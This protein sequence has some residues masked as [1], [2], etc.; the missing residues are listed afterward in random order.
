MN[1]FPKDLILM[2]RTQQLRV[3]LVGCGQI[4]DAHLQQ[5]KLLPQ[6]E[7][8]GVCD[9]E[10]LLAR[11][12]AERFNVP[13][14]F[15]SVSEM[16][17]KA[18]PDVVH[19]TTPVQAHANLATELL[20]AG[21]H[22]YVEKPFTLNATDARRVLDVAQANQ[23]LVCLGH[24]QLFDPIWLDCRRIVDS[25]AIGE[26]QHVDSVLCYPIDGPFGATVVRDPS[27]WV[28]RLPGGLFHNTMSHPLYRITEFLDDPC[29]ALWAEWFCKL[30]SVPFPTELRVQLRGKRTTGS[31]L[32]M[33]TTKPLHRLTRV[34]GTKGSFE[35][36]LNSQ[37]IRMDRATK[38]PGAL[39]RLEAPLQQCKEVVS[40]LARNF[41]RFGRG[42]FNYFAGMRELFRRFYDSILDGA[43]PPIP[44]AE[45]IR[46][47]EIMDRIFENCR[48]QEVRQELDIE[49]E[50]RTEH[51]TLRL[52]E[53][54]SELLNSADDATETL[55][56]IPQLSQRR[57][58]RDM[59]VPAAAR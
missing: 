12:A 5:I 46:V 50:V 53:R 13:G 42:E 18:K 45:V 57:S 52:L 27:H 4:A 40:N 43:A 51:D 29:P 2:A 33:S 6:A 7:L 58:A 32:F 59:S 39:A 10:P 49:R 47:T 31:L 38:L 22:V 35:V 17:D 9:L 34:Y 25:G 55:S 48:A 14:Q 19:I 1:T 26:V 15:S 20:A 41:R 21:V 24:D 28:R 16:L 56:E 8:V 11:Q 36:D 54:A 3:A 23:R 44:Y 37:L 30:E